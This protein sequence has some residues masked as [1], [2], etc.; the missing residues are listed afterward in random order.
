MWYNF[1]MN[2]YKGQTPARRKASAKYLT[3]KVD[4]IMVRVPKGQ[5][6]LLQ[7][8]ADKKGQ[9]LNQYCSD[10]LNDALQRDRAPDQ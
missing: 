9:S 1:D 7:D 6:A 4:S 2:E 8:A 10:A 5:K 3:T